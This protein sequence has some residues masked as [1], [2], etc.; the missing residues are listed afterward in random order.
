MTLA[1]EGIKVVEVTTMAAAPMA[2]RLLGDW[3]AEVIHVENPESGDP[4]RNWV[5]M[6]DGT[7]LPPEIYYHYWEN[8]NRNKKSVT[9]DLSQEGGR[10]ILYELLKKADVFITNL[11]PNEIIKLKLGYGILSNLNPRLIYGS[12]TGF[13]KK[14]P[15]KNAPVHDTAGFWARSGFLYMLQQDGM[16]PPSPGFRTLAA[17]DK[18]TALSM[19]CGV[20]LALL[21]RGQ[22][23]VGQ[24]V[25]IS[26]F[27]TGIYALVGV[28]LALGPLEQIYGTDMTNTE[29]P[30]R[31]REDV[32]PLVIS[33]ETRDG[34]WLQLS[35]AP[36]GTYWPGLCQAIKREELEND[37]RF[38]S[39]E[40]R[41]QNQTALRQILEEVFRSKTLD[42][43]KI[44]LNEAGLIW[45]PI[46]TP[47]EVITDPQARANDIFT[48]YD[49]PVYGQIEVV[50]NPIKLSKAPATL[51]TPAPEFGQHTEEVLLELGYTWNDIALFKQQKVI[52]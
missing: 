33:Y 11:R 13:G 37:P 5:K 50:A 44:I 43:W 19:A 31:E 23:G 7:S 4:W 17:G 10:G 49:H 16:A 41:S 30:R 2:A 24:E 29:V 52:A 3:G 25:D 38:N 39:I 27:H 45:A 26:L 15:D 32:S 28:A 34:R 14:G 21:V 36:A 9:I 42:E 18:L 8:Y 48:T 35:L 47:R 22:T 51:R 46:Q 20:L 12:L 6:P 40:S 1:L